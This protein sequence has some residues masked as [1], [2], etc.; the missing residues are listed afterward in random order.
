MS[1]QHMTILERR[2]AEREIIEQA[3][4]IHRGLTLTRDD[5][6]RAAKSLDLTHVLAGMV[7]R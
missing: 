3:Q 5:L 6:T 2:K 1:G 4:R 7:K